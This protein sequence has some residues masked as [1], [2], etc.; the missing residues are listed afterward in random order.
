MNEVIGIKRSPGGIVL[1]RLCVV[2]ASKF[3]AGSERTFPQFWSL[4]RTGWRSGS[5][6]GERRED[7]AAAKLSAPAGPLAGSPCVLVEYGQTGKY[8]RPPVGWSWRRRLLTHLHGQDKP[9]RAKADPPAQAD[10]PGVDRSCVTGRSPSKETPFA[11]PVNPYFVLTPQPM[12]DRWEHGSHLG[13]FCL[14]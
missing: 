2:K 6:R 4:L 10:P 7:A 3:K 9:C 13:P 12:L 1:C 11:Q 8:G 14:A 5:G